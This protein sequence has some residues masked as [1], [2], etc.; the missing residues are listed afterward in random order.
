MWARMSTRGSVPV[1]TK[2]SRTEIEE[3]I[4]RR[5]IAR[6]AGKTIC[7][8]EVARALA[9]DWRTLMPEVRAV[10]GRMADAGHIDVTQRGQRVNITVARGPVRLSLPQDSD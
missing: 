10:A 9:V 4:K 1:V 3:E 6:G 2:P 7:P 8:S 5:V